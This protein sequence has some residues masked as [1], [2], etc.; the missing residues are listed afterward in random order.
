MYGKRIAQAAAEISAITLRPKDPYTW[1]SGYRMPIYNDNR[2]HLRYPKNRELITDAFR[3]SIDTESMDVDVISG[4][5]TAGIAPAAGLAQRLQKPLLIIQD[6]QI[7]QFTPEMIQSLLGEEDLANGINVV[8]TTCPT[9]IVPGVWYANARGLPFAYVREKKKGHGLQQQI[10][11]TIN[12]GDKVLLFDFH[13]GDSYRERAVSALEQQGATVEATISSNISRRFVA[14]DV[15]GINQLH[16]EDLV[17]TAGSCIKEI[18]FYQERGANIVHCLAI[19]SYDFPESL[20]AFEEVGVHLHANL[21][22]AEM[23]QVFLELGKIT[24]D[25]HKMLKSW[26]EDA[27]NWGAKHGFPKVEKK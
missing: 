27:F 23:L 10:E 12:P 26:R 17:S 7:R 9:S 8:A 2:E 14:P 25:E 22:Y 18:K 21:G 1:A 13:T 19:F 6:E 24:A 15:R 3:H 5:S 11:G 20:E 4:T 16:V